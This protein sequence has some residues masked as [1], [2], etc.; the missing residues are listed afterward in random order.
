VLGSALKNGITHAEILGAMYSPTYVGPYYRDTLLYIAA[1]EGGGWIEL[2]VNVEL[3]ECDV[4]FHAMPLA[5]KN[6]ARLP[7]ED[8]R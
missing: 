2:L 8:K 7:K 6:E 1:R 5:E 3:E 4:V